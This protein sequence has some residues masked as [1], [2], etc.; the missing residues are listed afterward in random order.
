MSG[1]HMHRDMQFAMHKVGANASVP[2]AP[3]T[4]ATGDGFWPRISLEGRRGSP[5]PAV[6]ETAGR[7]GGLPGASP[8]PAPGAQGREGRVRL[9]WLAQLPL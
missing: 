6:Q 4:L 3:E 2:G 1:T 5:H 9:A 8:A 7:G